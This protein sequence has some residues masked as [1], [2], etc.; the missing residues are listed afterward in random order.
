MPTLGTFLVS[1]SWTP[2]HHDIGEDESYDEQQRMSAV[3]PALL[4]ACIEAL[5]E[6]L[7]PNWECQ[8]TIKPILR[9]VKKGEPSDAR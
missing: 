9:A 4:K 7:R 6:Q 2:R 1:L 3:S 8:V 5:V